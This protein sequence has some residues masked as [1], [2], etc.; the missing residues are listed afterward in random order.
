VSKYKLS[1]TA[2]EIALADQID[3][4]GTHQGHD[5]AREAYLKNQQPIL[6][7]LSSLEQRG[8]I[9]EHWVHYWTDPAYNPGRIKASRKGLFERNGCSGSDIY[10]HPHF[11]RHLRYLLFGSELPVSI[12]SAFIREA[13][14]PEW[15]SSS[16]AIPLGK[17]ARK[18]VR[19]HGMTGATAAEE[20]FKLALDIGLGLSPA[21]VLMDA[22]KQVR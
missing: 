14:D 22:V 15:V 18:Q 7:L 16:D 3:F 13:G 12:R 2:D 21:L 17:Y 4:S 11:I 9:P 20:F 6:D 10:I 8:G 5:A 1:L 19:E